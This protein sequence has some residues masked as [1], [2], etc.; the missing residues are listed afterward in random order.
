MP[1]VNTTTYVDIKD[2]SANSQDTTMELSQDATVSLDMIGETVPQSF[3][4][5]DDFNLHLSNT[6]TATECSALSQEL[7]EVS[8]KH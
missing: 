4:A 2:V 1:Y 6:T 8:F 3:P 5:D 7:E